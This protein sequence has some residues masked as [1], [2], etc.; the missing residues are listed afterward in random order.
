M[1]TAFILMAQYDGKAVVPLEQVCADYFGGMT[2][3]AFLRKASAGEIGLPIV[4]M[5]KGQKAARGIPVSDLADYLDKQ[6]TDARRE[7]E[8]LRQTGR[9]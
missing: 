5:D 3:K 9:H 7:C 6:I 8:A 2:E 1:K 4:R